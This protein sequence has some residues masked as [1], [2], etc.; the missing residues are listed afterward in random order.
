M[1]W[2]ASGSYA[3]AKWYANRGILNETYAPDACWRFAAS[4]Y[5][6]AMLHAAKIQ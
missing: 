1:R 3:S 2:R 5:D 4:A 6:D